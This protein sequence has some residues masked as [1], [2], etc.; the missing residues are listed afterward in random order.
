VLLTLYHDLGYQRKGS[1]LS[2]VM[3]VE[4]GNIGV[5]GVVCV[6]DCRAVSIVSNI[7]RAPVSNQVMINPNISV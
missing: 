3:K 4:H 5:S 1:V 6:P 7:Y 2:V